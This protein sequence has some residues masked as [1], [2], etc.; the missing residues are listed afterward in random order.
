MKDVDGLM[1]KW[2][3][4]IADTLEFFFFFTNWLIYR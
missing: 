1:Q 2:C 4:S 3:N